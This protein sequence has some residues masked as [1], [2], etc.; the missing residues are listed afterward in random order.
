[1]R[2]LMTTIACALVC[3][4]ASAQFMTS[5][6]NPWSVRWNETQTTNFRI[7]YPSGA[8]SL[9]REYGKSLEYFRI[10]NAS[11][12][13]FLV[14]KEFQGK[15]PVILHS[16]NTANN[17]SVTWTPK[18]M[19]IYT[20]PD[21]YF[22]T[23]L[24]ASTMLAVH[25]GRHAA[26]MQFVRHGQLKPWHFIFGEMIEGGFAGLF[27]GQPL[28][29]GDAVVA[30]TAL[31][32]SGRGRQAYFL[33][34]MMPAFDS[35][36]YRDYWQWVYGGQRKYAPDYYRAGY[37]LVSG[38]RVFF[39]EPLFVS[40]YFS[41]VT[42]DKAFREA[43]KN[44][45]VKGSGAFWNLQK[46]VRNASDMKFND[47]FRKIEEEY[48]SIW[49]AEAEARAPFDR[50]R[51]VS[52][53]P[54]LHVEY[55]G[56]AVDAEGNIYS[57]KKGLASVPTLVKT[58]PD[59]KEKSIR[60]FSYNTSALRF[61]AA[62][63][64]LYWTETIPDVRWEMKSNSAIRYIDL[65]KP[66]EI[67][68]LVRYGKYFNSVPSPDG[69]KVAAA[70][71]PMEG[72]SRLLVFDAET[73][74]TLDVFQAPSGLQVTESTWLG[75]TI[76]AVAISDSGAGIYEIGTEGFKAVA[77]P[78]PVTVS[79]LDTFNGKISFV[80]DR[81]GVNEVY[82]LDPKDSVLTQMTS[83]RYGLGDARWSARGDTLYYSSVA[84]SDNPGTYRRGTMLYATAVSDLKP[85]Q[86]SN[87]EIHH[88]TVA[89]TLSA[90]EKALA[91]KAG[92]LVDTNFSEPERFSKIR[93]PRFHSWAPLYF[94]YDN[95]NSISDDKY[96]EVGAIGATALF[97]NLLGTGYGSI[98]YSLHEDPYRDNKWR[99]SFHLNYL[100]SGFFPVIEL[101]ADFGDQDRVTYKRLMLSGKDG[102]QSYVVQGYLGDSPL[103]E[104]SAN[105]YVPLNF[106]SGGWRRGII[107]QVRYSMNNNLYDDNVYVISSETVDGSGER[108]PLDVI[109]VGKESIL[110]KI[111]ASVRGYTMQYTPSSRIFPRLGIGAEAGYGFYPGHDGSY[112]STAY[113][114]AYGYLPGFTDTHGLKI[115]SSYQRQFSKGIWCFGNNTINSYPR[116]FSD[117]N[118]SGFLSSY[119][120]GQFLATLDYAIPI[121]CPV[122][123]S[124]LSPLFYVK[125][126]ELTPFL[127]Y[128]TVY[129]RQGLPKELSIPVSGYLRFVSAGADIAARLSNFLWLP[130][131]SK[132]GIRISL[133][134]HDDFNGMISNMLIPTYRGDV[135][136]DFL[137]SIDF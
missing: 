61:D 26:Q 125:R 12:T 9:A 111:T 122:G 56:N 109:K 99:N 82:L 8:D 134:F 137:F 50:M 113:V 83:T 86:V 76:Y 108:K 119:G 97:Q 90:Q 1:M 69:K 35:G 15:F 120:E 59:G 71:Y 17:G 18:R 10:K 41:R 136:A 72:G 48:R 64:R 116:G 40:D 92:T 60:A 70:E 34:Y 3:A 95:I 51:Q 135:N 124:A 79:S 94:N 46:T 25:E 133:N 63:N 89:E 102:K 2:K 16:Y 123:N 112:A 121:D 36:D 33:N 132:I 126:F 52:P 131:E 88:Y 106:S 118:I 28:L 58:S 104:A 87:T 49:A 57:V 44:K 42:K 53:T 14:G 32:N 5:G 55:G 100:Y 128:A 75:D 103:F 110:R 37:M 78:Q 85:R 54:R 84:A 67:K 6:S 27:P 96:Y 105:I 115:T 39:D 11:S 66:R 13:G 7:I 38:M 107:P 23:P 68:N 101:R 80:S 117:T 31:T 47:A 65:D 91:G 4:S 81:S 20:V 74:E 29:E 43:R 24:P 21:A 19:E 130:F 62:L 114:Y 30:E 22:P 45:E 93:L 77:S 98:G 127:D 129:L 73:G